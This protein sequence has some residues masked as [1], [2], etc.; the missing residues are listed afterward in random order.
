MMLLV[1]LCPLLAVSGMAG[2]FASLAPEV[3]V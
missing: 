3:G 2:A 1:C